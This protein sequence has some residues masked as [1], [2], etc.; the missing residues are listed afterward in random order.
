MRDEIE[1]LLDDDEDMA[2]LYLSRKWIQS[3]QSEAL[4]G[5]GAL[6]SIAPA[7]PLLR[8]ISSNRS[9][10]IVTSNYTDDNDVEDLEM[11]LE[12]YF[13]QLDGTRNKI[14]SVSTHFYLLLKI[15]L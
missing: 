8:R 13:M 12:A 10:S 14:L 4:L 7:V 2:Q 11:L 1:H 15:G 9:G 6:N 3:Q 5:T